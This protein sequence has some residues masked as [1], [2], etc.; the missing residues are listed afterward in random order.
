MAKVS[1]FEYYAKAQQKNSSKSQFYTNDYEI[2]PKVFTSNSVT[3]N[4]AA[5]DVLVNRNAP[6]NMQGNTQR[7]IQTA[8][9]Q[10]NTQ[11]N[12]Q[13]R[14]NQDRTVFL[15]ENNAIDSKTGSYANVSIRNRTRIDDIVRNFDE[16]HL[17]KK[18]NNNSRN[19]H[20]Y[21]KINNQAVHESTKNSSKTK[22]CYGVADKTGFG[23]KPSL[24]S[25]AFDRNPEYSPVY[26]NS[27]QFDRNF[28]MENKR[29]QVC[30]ILFY[31][32]SSSSST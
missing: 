20:V 9:I 15:Q 16:Q 21:G 12:T 28:D 5:K 26:N 6:T 30:W 25:P 3:T 10:A 4:M 11:R 14:N 7:N 23:I 8:N 18:V 1:K 19:E 22:E 29:V 31:F 2:S 27:S 24:P 32:K 17:P 13:T